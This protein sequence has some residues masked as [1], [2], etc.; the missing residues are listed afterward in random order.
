MAQGI[1]LTAL[2]HQHIKASLNKG[3]TAIDATVGNGYD[4]CFLAKQVGESGVVF[5]FD[6]QQQA[7]ENSR[8][9]VE[10]ENLAST[11]R[12]IHCC[13]SQMERHIPDDKKGKI[14]AITF[15]LGYLPHGEH[16]IITLPKTTLLALNSSLDLLD[17]SGIMTI[18]AYQGH[19]GGKIETETVNQWVQQLSVHNYLTQIIPSSDKPTA[20]ILFI[21]QKH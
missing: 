5:G 2:A 21:V 14:K 9:R 7:I 4:C 18:T 1:S 8:E 20:P 17:N 6:I 19:S 16:S 12:L 13:H 3:D 11:I 15:N 10:K